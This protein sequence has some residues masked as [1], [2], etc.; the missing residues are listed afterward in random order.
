M[1]KVRLQSKIQERPVGLSYGHDV[2]RGNKSS[3]GLMKLL[4]AMLMAFLMCLSVCLPVKAASPEDWYA[5]RGTFMQDDGSQ[6]N[7][8][9]LQLLPLD[10]GCVLFEF[11]IMQGSEAEGENMDFRLPGTFYVEDDG[12]GTWEEETEDGLASLQFVIN[13]DKVTVTQT[14]ILPIPVEGSYTWLEE[15]LEVTEE[16]A[17][18]LLEGLATAATSLTSD[19]RPYHLEMSNVEVDNWFYDVKAIFTKTNALIGEFLIAKDLSA[20]YR[21]DTETPILIYGSADSMMEA[22]NDVPVEEGDEPATVVIAETG[23]TGTEDEEEMRY[24][25]PLVTAMPSSNRLVLGEKTTVTPV[26]PGNVPASIT[27]T[28]ENPEV[29]TV[30]ADGVIHAIAPG[31]AVINGT[32][33][34]DGSE[35]SFSFEI[36][37][38]DKAIQALDIQTTLPVGE[39]VTMKARAIGVPDPITWSVSDKDVAGIDEK[40]GLFKGKRE[41]RLLMVAQAGDLRREWTVTVGSATSS[42]NNDTAKSFHPV[43]LAAIVAAVFAIGITAFILIKR[44]LNRKK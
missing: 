31:T 28:S 19:N 33:S 25:V 15:A 36:E 2:H 26:T 39:S 41:G 7:S 4:T 27:G 29:A 21:I 10:N 11:D 6:Y 37:V 1:K 9:K 40:T 22:V 34:V 30:D 3:R 12:T 18:E 42:V 32:L 35:K 20:V 38:W 5:V 24:S 16:C 23:E 44:R 43:L 13:G 8:G 14:G 17:G